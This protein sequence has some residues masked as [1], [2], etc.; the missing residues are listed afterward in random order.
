[1]TASIV[2]PTAAISR[3]EAPTFSVMDAVV[4]GLMALINIALLPCAE[5][6]HKGR[7]RGSEYPRHR[8]LSHDRSVAC[9]EVVR[10]Q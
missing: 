8:L 6:V 7:C 5:H 10:R 9:D 4:F 3:A 1:L 2:V